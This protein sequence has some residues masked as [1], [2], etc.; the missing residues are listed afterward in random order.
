MCEWAARARVSGENCYLDVG[1]SAGRAI[2]IN[3]RE[4]TVVDR[5]PVHFRRPAGQLPLP[6]PSRDGSIE[7]LRPYVNLTE[8]DFRLL[9]RLDGGG[10]SSRGAVSD[11]GD[12]W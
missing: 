2:R 8:P 6:I 3:A 1:D 9:D 4:W 12:S 10:A 5:P 11:P 7:L